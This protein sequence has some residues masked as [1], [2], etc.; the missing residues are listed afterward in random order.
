MTTANYVKQAKAAYAAR[1]NRA[2]SKDERLAK[3]SRILKSG[4]IDKFAAAQVGPIIV[5]LAYQGVVRSLL[6]EDFVPT[7]VTRE[8][9]ALDDLG[10]AYSLNA[11]E[12]RVKIERFEGKKVMPDYYR[13]A[14]EW[15][16]GRADLEFMNVSVIDYA[17]DQTVQRIMEKEDGDY[18]ALV[19][20]AVTDWADTHAAEAIENPNTIINTDDD[21]QL[22]TFLEASARIATQRLSGTR[23]VMNPADVYDIYKWDIKT[24]GLTF[25]EDF[26]AGNKVVNFGDYQV[27][28]SDLLERGTIYMQPD[29]EYVGIMSVRYA[30]EA[31]DD[32]TGISDF[33]VRKVYNELIAQLI[34][35]NNGLTKI[36]KSAG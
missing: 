23:L 2:L 13:I 32:P 27:V 3:I 5:R 20:A 9:D 33:K 21:F 7:G 12:G 11:N 26:I 34:L 30:L 8:Y 31:A 24:V 4:G 28:Q 17:E 1:G 15:E 16:V 6:V 29:P 19:E 14:S 10:I 25:K 35:N 22:N 18:F 36:V